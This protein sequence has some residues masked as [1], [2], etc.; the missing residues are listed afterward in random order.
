MYD[1]ANIKITKTKVDALKQAIENAKITKLQVDNIINY[2]NY[3][4]LEEIQNKDYMEICNRL[5]ALKGA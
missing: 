3:N 5:K 2:F 1:N 4:K